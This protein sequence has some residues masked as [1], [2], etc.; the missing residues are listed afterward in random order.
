MCIRDRLWYCES[1]VFFEHTFVN[2]GHTLLT[3]PPY[4]CT[5]TFTYTTN[6]W[7]DHINHFIQGRNNLWYPDN[8]AGT[9]NSLT[10]NL[11]DDESLMLETKCRVY[12]ELDHYRIVFVYIWNHTLSFIHS[13]PNCVHEVTV[14]FTEEKYVNIS[15]I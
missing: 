8:S 7:G 3:L 4:P 11:N 9:V 2:K 14:M 10:I 15:L 6:K 1:S 13:V 12:M 5:W